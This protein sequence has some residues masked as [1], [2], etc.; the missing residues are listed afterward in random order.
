MPSAYLQTRNERSVTTTRQ[1]GTAIRRD[2]SRRPYP[3]GGTA[4]AH[5][6]ELATSPPNLPNGNVTARLGS[7]RLIRGDA[8]GDRWPAAALLAVCR[9]RGRAHERLGFAQRQPR[10][11]TEKPP[12]RLYLPAPSIS[13][14]FRAAPG[15]CFE[16]A[17]AS[18]RGVG[19]GALEPSPHTDALLKVCTS[20]TL[21]PA[22][23]MPL[24][25]H[26]LNVPAKLH[27]TYELDHCCGGVDAVTRTN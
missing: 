19:G 16:I 11:L 14:H 6:P 18:R 26:C 23:A 12:G 17:A 9:Q 3:R 25:Q 4:Q 27:T 8:A 1:A 2:H 21:N 10:A 24:Q 13:D 5:A 7:S 20:T 15:T 22:T